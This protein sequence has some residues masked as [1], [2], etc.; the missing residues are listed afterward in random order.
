MGLPLDNPLVKSEP[1]IRFYAG[2]PLITPQGTRLGTICVIDTK[3]KEID[4][5][6]INALSALSRQ[7]VL[8]LELRRTIKDLKQAINEKENAEKEVK[9]L[10]N[11]L[12]ICLYCKSIRDDENYWHKVDDYFSKHSDITLSHGIC[13]SCYP[14]VMQ[15][16]RDEL[17]KK[18]K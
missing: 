11:I 15:N 17:E 3:P 4:K 13:P 14:T 12:P 2:A 9:E 18:N 6:Q 16:F 8:Q 5:A 1:Y 10:Q 7:V